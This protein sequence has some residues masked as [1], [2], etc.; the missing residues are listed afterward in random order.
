MLLSSS[1]MAKATPT[2]EAL[3][4]NPVSQSKYSAVSSV[5]FLKIELPVLLTAGLR[6]VDDGIVSS[7]SGSRK[8]YAIS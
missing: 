8:S 5:A 6:S 1:A 4:K 3:T 2:C 7:S